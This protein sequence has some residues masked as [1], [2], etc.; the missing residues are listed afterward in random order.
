MTTIDL[1]TARAIIA[2][3]LAKGRELGLAPLSVVVLDPASV[4]AGC[5]PR[6]MARKR[7]FADWARALR[8]PV[9]GPCRRGEGASRVATG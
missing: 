7:C 5:R 2:A 1:G 3:T 6:L 8:C 4:R 9:I